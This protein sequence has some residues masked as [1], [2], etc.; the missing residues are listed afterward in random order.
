MFEKSV[1]NQIK[2]EKIR[3]I[4]NN[5]NSPSK[6]GYEPVNQAGMKKRKKRDDKFATLTPMQKKRAIARHKAIRGGNHT[7][8]RDRVI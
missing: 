4:K 1:L 3:A 8:R 6:M 5:N 2:N 7:L